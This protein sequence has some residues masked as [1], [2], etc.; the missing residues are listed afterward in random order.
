[1]SNIVDIARS[2]IAA[3]RQALGVTGENIANVNTEG[4]RRR[5]V[6]TVQIGG[7][8][9]SVTTLA[10]GGQGVQVDQIRRAFDALLAGRLR[11]ASG[12]MRASTVTVDAAKAVEAQLLPNSGGIDVALEDFFGAMGS[13]ASSPADTALRRVAIESGRTL[14]AAFQNVSGGLMR[15]RDDTMDEVRMTAAALTTDLTALSELQQKFTSNTGTVGALNPLHDERDRL[16][17]AIAAKVGV[18]V[19]LD[20]IGRA[21]VTLGTGGGGPELLGYD[22]P[23]TVSAEADPDL[24]L[25]IGLAGTQRETRL[26]GSGALGGYRAALGGIDD[27]VA[28]VDGLARKIAGEMNAIHRVGLDLTGAPGGDMFSLDSWA[29]TRASGNQGF[30]T[31]LITPSGPDITGPLTLVRDAAQGLWRAEDANGTVLAQADKLLVLP[32][33]TIRMEGDPADGDRFTLTPTTGKAVNMR[34]LPETPARLAAA[35]ATL[36][37]P[38]PGNKG[39]A[40]VAMAPTTVAPPAL[41]VLPDLLANATDA[42]QAVTLRNAGVVGFIPAGSSA[43]NLASL[44]Q[45]ASADM[46]AGAAPSSLSVTSAGIT[47]AFNLT[48]LANGS[49]RPAGYTLSDIAAALN[50]GRMA[51]AGGVTLSALGMSAQAS[52][53]T[54]SLSLNTGNFTAASLD[55]AAANLTPASPQGGTLQIFT[56]EGRQIAGTPMAPADIALLF[57]ETNGFLAGAQY[58][59][60]YLNSGY[61]GLELAATQGSGLQSLT[62]S[63]NPIAV[64]NGPTPAPAA[65]PQPIAIDTGL[66]L[67]GTLTLPEGGTARR[68]AQMAAAAIPGLTATAQ[69]AVTL[70]ASTDG[71]LSFRLAG[72]NTTPLSV[73]GDVA[74][75]R[76]DALAL[77][78][79]A[80]TGAT[81]ISAQLSPDGTR[82]MLVQSGGEDIRITG[83]THAAGGTVAL[84]AADAAGQP[85]GAVA[86]LGAGADSARI[87]GQMTLRQP[88]AFA[89][90]AAGTRRDSALD[91]TAGGLVTRTTSAAGAVTALTFALDPALDASLPGAAGPTRYGLSLGG[92]S[93]TL[94]TATTAATTPADV[95]SGLAARLRDGMPHASLTGGPVSQ[96]PP[97][98]ATTVVRLDGR[99]YTLRMTSGAVTV[100]GPEPS[101]LSAS[102]GPDM[103][104]TLAVNGGSTDSGM[105]TLPA[106]ANGAP[107]GLSPAS[108]PM[109]RLTGQPPTGPFP[110]TVEIEVGGTRHSLTV[111]AGPA[112][113]L[114]AGFPGTASIAQG[115]VR[116]DIPASAGAVRVLPGGAAA[117]FSSLGASV[118]ADGAT[119]TATASDGRPLALGTTT[120]AL[121]GQRLRLGNLPPEDLIVVM[122][123]SG[124]LRM[125]GSVTAGSVPATPPPVELRVTDATTGRVE[126]FDL[127]TGHSIGTRTLNASGGAVIGGLSVSVTGNPATG[128]G[129]RL[130]ANTDGRN[131]GR[132]LDAILAL[133][134]PDVASGKGGFARILSD[135]Q[136]EVG[137]RAAA[138]ETKL[139]SDTAIHDTVRRADAAQGAVDLDREAARLL[140]LQ[141]AYQ[142]SAQ[143]MTVAKDL[144]DTLLR[145]L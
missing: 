102:F 138:A 61:R 109:G 135:L 7:A 110:A 142:A 8:K 118:S 4:Y 100:S 87:G 67:P 106:G 71:R 97:E 93:V 29:V 72:T 37:A 11:T 14:A 95:A 15:L 59:T 24:T 35:V 20:E 17:G 105:I 134:F 111:T 28:Q 143:I 5:E 121:A 73:S 78:V 98:G 49:P 79:N 94:D 104:L 57:T 130:T 6:T 44:G 36:V 1:M 83:L 127:A 115:T 126:L 107:F 45:P 18:T 25:R 140:E 129:F 26:V 27:A 74:G 141:Q 91:A 13:L 103:R 128:D 77:S 9:T 42:G 99:D 41:P 30:A 34:F 22:G 82:L 48:T 92:R 119:L 113:T 40:S 23:A 131:D 120:T 56:R 39:S 16:L 137:T 144:F 58:N 96:L 86:T 101:R 114:P 63:P 53:G 108:A 112:V 117:G 65:A 31:A 38:A 3:Y 89:V 51:A 136:S 47:T 80:L 132:A 122:T 10:T 145:S 43:A 32:N 19:T 12:D 2:S 123:G 88:T 125:A 84:Q 46:V 50:D 55:G 133:R 90:T 52:G 62:L 64:W 54:L 70:T 76:L 21:R 81:G 66:G 75:G 68:L 60:A 139:N 69:T 33:L 116:L 124:T 85:V